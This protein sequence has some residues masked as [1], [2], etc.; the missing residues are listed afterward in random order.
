M[1]YAEKQNALREAAGEILDDGD[2]FIIVKK[3]GIVDFE[4]ENPERTEKAYKVRAVLKRFNSKYTLMFGVFSLLLFCVFFMIA[5]SFVAEVY[6]G[7]DFS[8]GLF[9]NW[10]GYGGLIMFYFVTINALKI[11]I[12]KVTF[13]LHW[14]TMKVEFQA[15]KADSAFMM[16]EYGDNKEYYEL[17]LFIVDKMKVLEQSKKVKDLNRTDFL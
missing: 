11:V 6:I 1:K 3:N 10:V 17:V 9:N 4:F 16:N 7:D 15:L 12:Q 14:P 8:L 13:F 2:R 5:I